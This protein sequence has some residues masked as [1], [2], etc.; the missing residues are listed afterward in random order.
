MANLLKKVMDYKNLPNDTTFITN[1]VNKIVA[2]TTFK[3]N[4]KNLASTIPVGTIVRAYHGLSGFLVCNGGAVSRTDYSALFGKL[5]TVFGPGDGSTTFNLPNLGGEAANPSQ[6]ATVGICTNGE[7]HSS[8][9]SLNRDASDPAKGLKLVISSQ[10]STGIQVPAALR[11]CTLKIVLTRIANSL[12]QRYGTHTAWTNTA[13]HNGWTGYNFS[14]GSATITNAASATLT[15]SLTADNNDS[16]IGFWADEG[17]SWQCWI[18]ITLTKSNGVVYILNGTGSG[19][20]SAGYDGYS[21]TSGTWAKWVPEKNL[22]LRS[23]IK[24]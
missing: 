5:G 14:G 24:Y 19:S 22:T 2:H 13:N 21:H 16:Y 15:R 10:G 17:T 6:N 20:A 11:P 23:Y 3:N 18:A 1:V 12:P 8:S 7:W 9:I 4:V